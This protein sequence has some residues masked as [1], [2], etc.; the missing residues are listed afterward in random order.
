MAEDAGFEGNLMLQSLMDEINTA[1]E[2]LN[3]L[4]FD[5]MSKHL[6]WK[7]RGVQY[8]LSRLAFFK[9]IIWVCPIE[10]FLTPPHPINFIHDQISIYLVLFRVSF[11]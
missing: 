8:I 6:N 1:E 3:N 10:R 7:G 5:Y 4:R 9:F 2:E 11:G